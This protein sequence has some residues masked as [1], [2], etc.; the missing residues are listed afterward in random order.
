MKSEKFAVHNQHT[1]NTFNTT[2][3]TLPVVL[4]IVVFIQLNK[5]QSQEKDEQRSEE[6]RCEDPPFVAVC[7]WV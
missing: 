2:Q 7:V 5:T 4:H 1:I 6:Q 3:S